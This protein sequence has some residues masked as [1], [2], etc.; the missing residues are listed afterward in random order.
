MSAL[1]RRFTKEQIRFVIGLSTVVKVLETSYA[2][3]HG[4][5]LEGLSRLFIQDVRVYV[6]PMVL[7]VLQTRLTPEQ[8]TGWRTNSTDELLEADEITPPPPLGHLYAYL[9]AA[10]LIEPLRLAKTKTRSKPALQAD[11]PLQGNKRVE[12]GLR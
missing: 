1:V 3:L 5:V 4:R 10:G 6:Y 12:T 7:D 8:S 9:L 11:V 2:D